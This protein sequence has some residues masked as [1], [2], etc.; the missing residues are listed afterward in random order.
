MGNVSSYYQFSFTRTPKIIFGADRFK[1]ISHIIQEMG[2]KVLIVTGVRSF[3]QSE[4]WTELLK[5]LNHFQI[6]YAD[7]CVSGE[8][9]PELVDT[10]VQQFRRENFEV[11]VAIGGGSV[12]DA[13]KAISAML[14]VG[15][16][17]VEYLEGVGS[18]VQ[19]PGL[20]IPFIAVPTTAG[21][22]SET[23]KNAVLSRVGEDGF[24]K[25][26]R[27]DNFVPDV[28]LIDPR[29]MLSCP[30][31]ITAAA[32]LDAFTQLLEAYVSTQSSPITDSLAWSGMECIKK[33]LIAAYT[34]G[35]NDLMARNG[36]AYAAMLSGITLTNAGLGIV[37][38]LA[39]PIGGFFEIPHG[40]VCGTLLAAAIEENIRALQHHSDPLNKT[41]LE[42]YARVGEL[43][44]GSKSE[45][46]T[47][48]CQLLIQELYEW[49]EMLKMPKL[50]QYG[51]QESDLNK[52]IE[53]TGNKNNPV[54]LNKDQIR[55]IL[56]KRLK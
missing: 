2:K 7:L 13:G 44:S 23:T 43:L 22:G 21:T 29:L 55:N 6:S 36:M 32:G 26:L 45:N 50:N 16:S 34:N 37:H 51:I 5:Q 27:H 30:P 35:A 8:P 41:A 25:S 48:N 31:N 33:Y 54:Q 3:R 40:V 47:E 14:P 56:L 18:G 39:S 52:I 49:T 1:E 9:S 38:G 28:A 46:V 12:I 42:K 24:K 53:K 11:V 19:H 17:V 20:K 10:T 15:E 4:N